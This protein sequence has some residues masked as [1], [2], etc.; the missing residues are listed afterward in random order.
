MQRSGEDRGVIALRHEVGRHVRSVDHGDNIAAILQSGRDEIRDLARL[1]FGRTIENENP[2]G[3]LLHVSKF[4]RV[5]A[6]RPRSRVPKL[7]DSL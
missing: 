3:G 7:E 4:R 2:L 5:T 1:P 6:S